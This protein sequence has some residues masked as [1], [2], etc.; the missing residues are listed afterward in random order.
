MEATT[1]L[2]PAVTKGLSA[3]KNYNP[4]FFFTS[5]WETPLPSSIS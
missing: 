3:K 4:Y 1:K 2:I 5:L